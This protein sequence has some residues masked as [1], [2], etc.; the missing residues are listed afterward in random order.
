MPAEEEWQKLHG[1]LTTHPATC[2]IW[3]DQPRPDI[4]DRLKQ[5]GLGVVAFNPCGNTPQTGD[6]LS[7]MH[8]N[9]KALNAK[10][11]SD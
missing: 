4:V 10:L 1:L 8:G 7:V 6:Y 5:M 11:E 3:E 9:I 2:I